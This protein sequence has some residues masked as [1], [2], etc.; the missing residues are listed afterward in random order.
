[1]DSLTAARIQDIAGHNRR[2]D[3]QTLAGVGGVVLDV[4]KLARL[5][6]IGLAI[7]IGLGVLREAVIAMVGTETV[8]KD[9]RHFHLDSERNLASWFESMCMSFAAAI[10]GFMALLSRGGDRKNLIPWTILAVVFLL[11]ASDEIVGFHEVSV[12]P[13]RNALHLSGVFYY[14]WVLIAAPVVAALGLYLVPFLFRL[15]R[16]TAIRFVVAGAVFVGAA[17]GTEFICGYFASRDGV[18]SLG[19]RFTADLQEC[20]EALGMVLFVTAL[21][22]HLALVSPTLRLNL[23]HGE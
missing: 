3:D 7:V 17:M 1:M 11:M 4:Q 18:D 12:K 9:L 20:F 14:S 22:R 10:L 13:L 2:A 8:L 19:Y 6:Q 16:E 23:R 21:L 15:P 5:L